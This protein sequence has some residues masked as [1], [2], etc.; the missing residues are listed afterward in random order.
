[1]DNLI[2]QAIEELG[3]DKPVMTSRVVGD[4]VE[5]TLYGGERITYAP[6]RPTKASAKDDV[7]EPANTPVILEG[8]TVAELRTRAADAGISGRT[9]MKKAELIE[10]LEQVYS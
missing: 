3:I 8:L 1:M 5:L 7:A 6:A 9:T 10:A 2:K 4:R